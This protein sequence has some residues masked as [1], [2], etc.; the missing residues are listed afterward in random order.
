MLSFIIE[1]RTQLQSELN[2]VSSEN[3][4]VKEY[5]HHIRLIVDCIRQIRKFIA[6]EPFPDKEAEIY[7]FKHQVPFFYCKFFYFVAMRDAALER[8][9]RDEE[10]FL[11]YLGGEK[12]KVAAFLEKYHKLHLY[13]HSDREDRDGWYTRRKRGDNKEHLSLVMD[14]HYCKASIVTGRLL[15]F[16]EYRKFI[17]DE[18]DKSIRDVQKNVKMKLSKSEA[19]E[20]IMTLYEDGIVFVDEKLATIEQLAEMFIHFF[21]FD[22]DDITSVDYH[23][24][25]RRKD[26]TPLLHRWLDTYEKRIKRLG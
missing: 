3:N 14:E 25:I 2:K 19:V 20:F 18:L 9:T 11:N 6:T 15:A 23:N 1:L 16:V 22:L 13:Y 12:E 21:P 5:D 4:A 17:Y 26:A 24:R 10:G 7:F 8:K